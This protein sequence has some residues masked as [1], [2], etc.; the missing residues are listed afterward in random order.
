MRNEVSSVRV[1]G[2]NGGVPVTMPLLT[3]AEEDDMREDD[4]TTVRA[5]YAQQ[6]AITDPRG[7]AHLFDGLPRDIAGLVAIVQGLLVH[8]GYAS[9]YGFDVPSERWQ[10]ISLRSIPDMLARIVA[11]DPAPLSVA[12]PPERRLVSLCRDYAVLLVSLL[13]HRG[14]PARLRVGFGGYFHGSGLAYWDHRIAEYWNAQSNHWV[15]VDP[16]FDGTLR[17]QFG[18]AADMLDMAD[19][20]PFLVAGD[21]WRRCRGGQAVPDEFGD[22]LTDIGWAPIRYALLGDLD[23]LNKTELIGP[24]TWHELI[25]KPEPDVTEDERRLLDDIAA[26]TTNAD[27]R[28]DELRA[29]YHATPYGQA[30][31]RRLSDAL[32]V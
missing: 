29:L 32:P 21:V 20:T 3:V 28:F 27:S 7:Y 14:V 30:V 18:I 9:L 10:E 24:D 22:S 2:T 11:L 8:P 26:L 25:D 4:A 15:L 19:D 6:S 1:T 16:M 31:R 23:A 12:R 5:Y 13:R 17:G